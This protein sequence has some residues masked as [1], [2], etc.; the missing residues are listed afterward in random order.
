MNE[1]VTLRGVFGVGA[2]QSEDQV[3]NDSNGLKPVFGAG[4]SSAKHSEQ[5]QGHKERLAPTLLYSEG[6]T[7]YY[8][9]CFLSFLCKGRGLSEFLRADQQRDACSLLL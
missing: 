1:R 5:R 8:S 9:V 7:I 2:L 6:N 3:L 4:L